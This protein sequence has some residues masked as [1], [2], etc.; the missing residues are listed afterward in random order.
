MPLTAFAN[1]GTHVQNKQAFQRQLQYRQKKQ[2]IV[3]HILFAIPSKIEAY[4]TKVG[5]T[6]SVMEN[7]LDEQ[8]NSSTHTRKT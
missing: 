3:Q 1:N 7:M 6:L 2:T 5:Y 4:I 8:R